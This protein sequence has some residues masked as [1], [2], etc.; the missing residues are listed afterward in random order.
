MIVDG[1]LTFSNMVNG[2]GGTPN[3]TIEQADATLVG[4]PG[5]TSPMTP[6]FGGYCPGPDAVFARCISFEIT[7]AETM[8]ACIQN[9]E[10]EQFFTR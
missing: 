7:P 3:F 4:Q 1:G 8:D 10:P 6:S 9:T 2:L 5:A